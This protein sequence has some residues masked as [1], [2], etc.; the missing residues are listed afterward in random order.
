[1]V[2]LTINKIKHLYKN[3]EMYIKCCD[4][5]RSVV[6][7]VLLNKSIY[8]CIYTSV[9]SKKIKFTNG[10]WHFTKLN[11]VLHADDLGPAWIKGWLQVVAHQLNISVSIKWKFVLT[12][13]SL[14][15]MSGNSNQ[16]V[17]EVMSSGC[18]GSCCLTDGSL[19][20]VYTTWCAWIVLTFWRTYGLHL[21]GD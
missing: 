16:R 6:C 11:S 14:M 3:V 7:T 2:W 9:K 18:C 10:I 17:K 1:M 21:Q 20:G 13:L 4:L 12:G 15:G 19:F 8:I 5:C